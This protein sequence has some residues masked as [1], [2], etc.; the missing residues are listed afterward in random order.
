MLLWVLLALHVP[1]AP[2]SPTPYAAVGLGLAVLA[3]VLVV[4]VAA[5]GLPAWSPGARAWFVGA[6]ARIRAY[7]TPRL[8]DP[9]AAGRPRPRAPAA[10]LAAI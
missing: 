10:V 2:G 7:R 1:S 6:R 9:D 3:A 4:A 5:A 8:S